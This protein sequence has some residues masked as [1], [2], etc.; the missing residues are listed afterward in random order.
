MKHAS[1]GMGGSPR[2]KSSTFQQ[3]D[4]SPTLPYE[5]PPSVFAP[6]CLLTNADDVFLQSQ[7]SGNARKY[8]LA[9]TLVLHGTHPSRHG[10]GVWKCSM[11]S[12]VILSG[13]ELPR[14]V[15]YSL[16]LDVLAAALQISD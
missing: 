3:R 10:Q 9:H 5:R 13:P 2:G 12:F 11:L 15:S 7:T 14:P 8:Q 4:N 16:V 6:H 1:T